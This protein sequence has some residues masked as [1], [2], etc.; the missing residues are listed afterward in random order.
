MI[1]YLSHIGIIS[2]FWGVLF[3][4]VLAMKHTIRGD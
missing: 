1:A 4:I 2:F 3:I